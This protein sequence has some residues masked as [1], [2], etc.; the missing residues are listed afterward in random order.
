MKSTQYNTREEQSQWKD[1]ETSPE[2][3]LMGG[4]NVWLLLGKDGSSLSRIL[5]GKGEG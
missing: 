5:N 4:L 1:R 3:P 2:D